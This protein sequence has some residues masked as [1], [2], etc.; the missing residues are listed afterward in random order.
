[1]VKDFNSDQ[2]STSNEF[3]TNADV[4]TLAVQ[5]LIENPVNP[6]TGK[7]INNDEKYAHE[8]YVT[9]SKDWDTNI[10]NGNVFLPGQWFAVRE[11]IWNLDNWRLLDEK[12]SIP[13][14]LAE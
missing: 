1:M 13:S 3:M 12:T 10:N 7:E 8:Q 11:N 14:E 5:D 2:F 9:I 4:A 6:F